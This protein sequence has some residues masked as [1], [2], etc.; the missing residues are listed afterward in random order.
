[1]KKVLLATAAVLVTLAAPAHADALYDSAVKKAKSQATYE[2]CVIVLQ[3]GNADICDAKPKSGSWSAPAPTL[4]QPAP[5][6]DAQKTAPI[7]APSPK[8]AAPAHADTVFSCTTMKTGSIVAITLGY[9][10]EGHTPAVMIGVNGQAPTYA[11]RAQMELGYDISGSKEI[12]KATWD[13]DGGGLQELTLTAGNHATV[14]EDGKVFAQ[15][16]RTDTLSDLNP[17]SLLMVNPVPLSCLPGRTR[18]TW[19]SFVSSI[20]GS[21][22]RWAMTC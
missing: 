4:V 6:Q 1:M 2:Q 19:P 14:S 11:V 7:P 8:L 13:H 12:T 9:N 20:K 10:N 21:W 16:E 5:V 17:A 18:R 15:C 3:G 22:V